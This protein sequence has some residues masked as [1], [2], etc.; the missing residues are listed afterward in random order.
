MNAP[1]RAASVLFLL[2]SLV[3]PALTGAQKPIPVP[4]TLLERE[5]VRTV[6]PFVEE[7]CAECHSSPDPEA[8]FD[9]TSFK[10]LSSV[11]EDFPHWTLLME[12]L[13]SS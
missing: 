3:T 10:S 11:L 4:E 9:L 12:R 1:R 6:R 13:T 5:F 2:G 8:Q 7:Y